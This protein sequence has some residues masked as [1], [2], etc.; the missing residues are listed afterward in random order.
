MCLM[1]E[2]YVDLC[3][4]Q[5]CIDKLE[6]NHWNL[7]RGRLFTAV[8]WRGYGEPCE[9]IKQTNPDWKDYMYEADEVE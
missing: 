9:H 8:L 1:C 3:K 6:P 4:E 5:E 2:Y 7:Y